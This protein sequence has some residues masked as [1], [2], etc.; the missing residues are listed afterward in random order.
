[1]LKA[2]AQCLPY[3]SIRPSQLTALE[4]EEAVLWWCG[5]SAGLASKRVAR[6]QSRAYCGTLG[7]GSAERPEGTAGR[8][9][10]RVRQSRVAGPAL[11]TPG[12]PAWAGAGR[13]APWAP[14]VQG[15]ADGPCASGTPRGQSLCAVASP[16]PVALPDPVRCC[17]GV[18]Q[19]CLHGDWQ[20]AGGDP[21]RPQRR[22]LQGVAGK[23]NRIF[24]S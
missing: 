3:A 5:S 14:W 13:P 6:P 15:G 16:G 22:S 11:R 21:G 18:I 1:M 7:P 24:P 4:T 8:R 10:E 17:W 23:M 20:T 12:S 19:T 9:C 2:A